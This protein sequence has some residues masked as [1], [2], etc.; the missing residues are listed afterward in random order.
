M[1][2]VHSNHGAN[3]D[4][5]LGDFG[6]IGNGSNSNQNNP[7]DNH[8]DGSDYHFH[9]TM[10]QLED[11]IQRQWQEQNKPINK[12]RTNL[13]SGMTD[14]MYRKLYTTMATPV[15][16]NIFLV[17]VMLFITPLFFAF[18]SDNE[19][20]F[21]IGTSVVLIIFAN[22]LFDAM[23]IYRIRKYVIEQVT[24]KYYK[25]LKKSWRGFELMFFTFV[26]LAIFVSIYNF[27]VNKIVIESK[28]KWTEKF[29]SYFELQ[30]YFT[31]LFVLSV[32]SFAFYV[33]FVRNIG[34]KA[35]KQ[36]RI[37]I[38]ESRVGSEHNAE[39]ADQML[40]GKIADFEDKEEM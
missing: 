26:S 14:A 35:I 18:K 16:T 33:L 25:I 4:G 6:Q 40:S 32:V 22:V 9:A 39:V 38:I 11:G 21:Y 7:K 24:N 30:E 1:S 27:A 10:Q 13:I 19:Y 2:V 23:V 36:Q 12:D 37:S 17:V 5:D 15:A 28:G 34:K 3:R 31:S 29:M 20:A 8:V